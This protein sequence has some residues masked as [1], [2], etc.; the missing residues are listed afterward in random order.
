MTMASAMNVTTVSLVRPTSTTSLATGTIGTVPTTVASYMYMSP[1]GVPIVSYPVISTSSLALSA[2]GQT[3]MNRNQA[4]IGLHQ[5]VVCAS[6]L[7]NHQV[8]PP[9]QK[10]HSNAQAL[11]PPQQVQTGVIRRGVTS[12]V[13]TQGLPPSQSMH[14]NFT[15]TE[16]VAMAATT[17]V[18]Q[19]T[20][21]YL[22]P[23]YAPPASHVVSLQPFQQLLV[24]M[25]VLQQPQ[26]DQFQQ[27]LA[28]LPT[29]NTLRSSVVDQ[30]LIQERLQQIRDHAVP[31]PQ[32]ELLHCC[33]S[34]N[35]KKKKVECTWPQ[36]YAFVGHLR[37][38][39]TYEQLNVEQFV[40]GLLRS[41]QLESSPNIR[42]NMVEYLTEL[43]QSVCDQGWVQAKGADSVVMSNM[44]DGIVTWHG[45]IKCKKIKKTYLLAPQAQSLGQQGKDQSKNIKN[46]LQSLA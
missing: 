15:G 1:V 20:A 3:V 38:R 32:G 33:D 11:P 28:G 19:V 9:P 42:A 27:Q 29:L 12:M 2:G 41:V 43:M 44:E 23:T 17:V 7:G 14:A 10:V 39:L 18:S 25:P 24:P 45:L 37:T 40:L 13:V 30:Q 34:N 21:P 26:G 5:A 6:T 8:L 36:D 22:V 46:W 35:K 31:Q 16:T 4:S